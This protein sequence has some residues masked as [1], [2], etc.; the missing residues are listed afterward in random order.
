MEPR[1]PHAYQDFIKRYPQL[2]QAWEL[3]G[4]AGHDGPIDP[5]ACR[6]LKLAV[7]IGAQ[8]EGAVRANVRKALAEG[9][10][11]AHVEQVVAIAAST[12]GMPAAVAAF[13]WIED[14]LQRQ[15]E[16]GL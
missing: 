13:T 10:T 15:P 14:I 11:R 3:L 9:L 12:V 7:A 5:P 6:L 2:A 1:P 8:R 16:E 4:Q